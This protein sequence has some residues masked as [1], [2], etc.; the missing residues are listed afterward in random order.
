MTIEAAARARVLGLVL[1]VARRA[2]W[3]L[4]RW[5]SVR[6]MAVSARLIC[7]RADSADMEP[8]RLVVA[9][10]A[11]RRADREVAAEAMAVLTGGHVRH[12]DR[13]DGV[14][15]SGDLAVAAAAEIRR[16]RL[17]AGLAMA[18]RARHVRAID[19]RAMPSALAHHAPLDRDMLWHAAVFPSTARCEDR[20]RCHRAEQHRARHGRADPIGWH[21]RH[22][23]AVSGCRLDHPS[24]CGLPPT[25][26]TAWQL[27]HSCSPA[28]P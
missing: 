12:P 16:R 21:I 22:G 6:A 23:I 25:P 20:D 15:R 2:R 4:E 28:P 13:I 11:A 14:E 18:V 7:V 17:E 19:V 8:L 9:A 10:H 1:L 3:H 26:P 5:R 24:G 27:T